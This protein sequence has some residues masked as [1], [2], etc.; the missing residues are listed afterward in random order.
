MPTVLESVGNFLNGR[1]DTHN[2]PELLDLWTPG[3]ETQV[4]VSGHGGEPVAGRRHTWSD[5]IREWWNIR[6]PKNANSEPEFH[7]YNLEWPLV[8]YTE[9]VGCTGWDWQSKCSRWVG[10]DFDSI[11]GHA[12]G[13]GVSDQE[14]SK[15]ADAAKALPFVEVRKSTGG[16]G[17]HLYVRLDAIPAANHTEHAALARAVLGMMSSETGF[18]F[19]AQIDACG[20]ILWIWHKKASAANEGLK[21]IK[22]AE[23]TLS[24]ADVPANWRDH[25]EVVTHKRSKVRVSGID[26]D[27]IDPFEAL[28]SAR[29]IIA[30]D[31]THKAIMESLMHSG[32]STIWVP[33]HH[34]LQTHSKALQDIMENEELKARLKLKGF[35]K[36]ISQGKDKGTP[37]C[38]MFP[39]NKGG[40]RVY[41]F[42]PGIVEAETWGQDRENWTTCSFNR[43]P[44][45]AAA[46]KA[47][48]GSELSDN[49]GFEFEDGDDAERVIAALGTNISLPEKLKERQ[50]VVRKNKDGRLLV[51]VQKHG[52]DEDRPGTGWV[53]KKN[54]WERVIDA[55]ADAKDD[56]SE[57]TKT[58]SVFR[59][60]RTPHGQEAGWAVR[61]MGSGGGWKRTLIKDNAKSALVIVGYQKPEIE[62][63]VAESYL[64]D[65]TLVNLP[66]QPEYPGNRQW[67]L[68]AA[69]FKYQ[70]SMEPGPH[71]HWDMVL[72]HCG[73]DLT[74]TLK[75]LDWAK[76]ANILTG[77][78]YLL[79]WAACMLR[80]PFQPLPYLFFFGEQNCGKSTYHEALTLLMTKGQ[81]KAD[82]SLTNANDFNGELANAIL[83][84]VEEKDISTSGAAA[85]NKIKDWVTGKTISIRKMR[86]D[87]YEQPNTTHWI[88]CANKR[89][90]CPIFPGD[91][92]ITVVYVRDLDCT[93]V[94]RMVMEDRLIQEAPFFLRTVLDLQL[95]TVDGRLRLPVVA[96]DSK[97]RAEESARDELEQFIASEC[98]IVNGERV[99]FSEF[100]QKFYEWLALESRYI[101]SKQ[102]VS[103]AM[104]LS[105]PVGTGAGNKSYIGNLS[106]TAPTEPSS[107]LPLIV[108]DGHLKANVQ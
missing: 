33:D 45:L 1:R 47:M 42:S 63:I 64:D 11:T 43:T 94:P 105:I 48:G 40:W 29:K 73:H 12:T 17:L 38:F 88:Q 99:L 27:K 69:Q 76:K 89:E 81:V 18:D 21:L 3:M 90:A 8:L 13:V 14:L 59:A 60:L 85:Y 52:K 97:K 16:S 83:C 39:L 10:F 65:W 54:H 2:A 31:E 70:P 80:D 7:D 56:E 41:R 72:H 86:T 107:N 25:V 103:K 102:K 101:W 24:S 4:N 32:Y 34:L 61:R 95:P 75:N 104:P 20:G 36:T 50:V 74:H 79:T 98:H 44:D 9:A 106:F 22:A 96:T 87:S 93:E 35:F 66:F 77:A 53:G 6:I 68:D 67:N 84:T 78:D 46:S 26:D 57:L 15:V 28:A 91:T 92:R 49:A 19:A 23:R 30:L 82:R 5:G 100:Y 58:D 71:P 108:V 55:S 37:N 51:R 62:T